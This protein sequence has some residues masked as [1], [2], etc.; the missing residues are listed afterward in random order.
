MAVEDRVPVLYLDIEGG[1][2]GSSRSLCE[3][4]AALDREAFLPV[5]VSARPGPAAA[6]YLALGVPHAVAPLPAWRPAERHN[7]LARLLYLASL[8]RLPRVLALLDGLVREHGV[9]LLHA[10]HEGLAPLARR[11]AARHGLPWVCHLRTRMHPS[12][13]SRGLYR[14][15]QGSAARVLCITEN[16]LEHFRAVLGPEFDPARAL[17]AH[18]CAALPAGVAPDPRFAAPEGVFTVVMLSNLSANRGTDQAVEVAGALK[19]RGREDFLFFLCGREASGRLTPWR[20]AGFVEAMRGRMAEL[21][22][23]RMVRL[24]GHVDRPEAALAAASA[25]MQVRRRANPWGREIMEAMAAG[26]PVLAV[27]AYQGFVEHGRGGLLVPEFS[28]QALAAALIRLKDE[29]G[30]ARAMGDFNR[31]KAARIFAPAACAARIASVYR[32]VL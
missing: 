11:L 16:E 21:G 26:L 9:R 28:A 32:E 18:N 27:G 13:W 8:R 30:L 14:L 31:A 7:L 29:P 25:L 15:I 20:R 22:V 12:A 24:P 5:V 2:G 10:N 17:V 23:E 3:L 1:F 6:R 19:A 4:V